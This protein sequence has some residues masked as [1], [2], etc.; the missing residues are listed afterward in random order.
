[1]KIIINLFFIS[2]IFLINYSNSDEVKDYKKLYSIK[3]SNINFLHD[4]EIFNLDGSINAVVEIPSGSI[5]KWK[6]NSKGD[7]IELTLKNNSLRKI[8]YIGH[9]T[10][11]GFIP[12]T[13]LPFKINGD[14]DAVDVL[15]LGNQLSIGQIVRCRVLGMLEMNDKSLIDNKI[16]CVEKDSYLGR[17]NSIKDLEKLAPRALKI[18]EIWYTNYKGEKIEILGMSKKKKTIKFIEDANKYYLDNIAN[19][20]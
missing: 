15:I 18:I 1:M 12:K 17:A 10:N 6:L 3:N 16:I 5:E 4:V 9:P 8:D 20:Q 7:A 14:G 13:L 2:I 19:K 11:Y